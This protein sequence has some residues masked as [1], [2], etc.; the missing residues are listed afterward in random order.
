MSSLVA[1]DKAFVFTMSVLLSRLTHS[2]TKNKVF[3]VTF[4]VH[5]YSVD[6][7]TLKPILCSVAVYGVSV[8]HGSKKEDILFF[9]F[10]KC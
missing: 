9:V 10:S 4:V 5:W 7:N 8:N 3:C 1:R 2:K 6:W